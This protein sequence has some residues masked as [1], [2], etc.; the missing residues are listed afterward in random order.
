M[1]LKNY[2]YT[3]YT[4]S[5]IACMAHIKHDQK[6]ILEKYVTNRFTQYIIAYETSPKVGEHIHFL[7]WAEELEDYHKLA[8]NI[9]KRKYNLRGKATKGKCRQ[10]GKVKEIEDIDRMMAYTVKDKNVTY[11]I[12]DSNIDQISKAFATS[13]QKNDNLTRLNNILLQYID[14]NKAQEY[15]DDGYG[16]HDPVADSFSLC[17]RQFITKYTTTYFELFEKVPTRNMIINAVVKYD[18]KKGI[19]WYLDT[20]HITNQFNNYDMEFKVSKKE[21]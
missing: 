1:D 17:R 19:Q 9:F 15:K 14:E 16:G 5:W 13:F 7:L 2:G 18:T 8:Q 21:T 3:I 10:Y 6:E 20:V 12:D 11:K 4:M